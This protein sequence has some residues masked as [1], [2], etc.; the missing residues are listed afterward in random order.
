MANFLLIHGSGHGAWCWRDLQRELT[1]RGHLARAIDM[2][3]SGD[4]PTPAGSVTMCMC[5][6]RIAAELDALGGAILVAHSWGGYPASAA[7]MAV[8]G[9]VAHLVYLCAYLPRDGASMIDRRLEAARQPVVN[10]VV[11]SPGGDSYTFR[12]DRLA[13]IF[14][15]DCAPEQVADAAQRLT[16]QAIA[17]QATPLD[18]TADLRALPKS[19]ITCTRDGA[20]PMELQDAM[21]DAWP[22]MGRYRLDSDH[23]PFLSQPARLA[24]VLDRIAKP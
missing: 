8:P 16:P 12:D 7:A 11:K 9:R 24:D 3:G 17:P 6:D 21:A 5:R 14:Y 19:Y 4:D 10:A 1:G 15:G 20:V 18:V 23:S 13:Q 22:E 2:P